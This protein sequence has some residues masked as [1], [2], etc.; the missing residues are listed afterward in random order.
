AR[1]GE[2]GTCIAVIRIAEDGR[3]SAPAI[4]AEALAAG[5]CAS[6]LE[7]VDGDGGLEAIMQ[8]TWPALAIVEA[9]VPA[10]RVALPARHGGWPAG[11]MP[12]DYERRE[13]EVRA[14]ALEQARARLD[15]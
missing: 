15:V 7:D 3:P 1:D 2:E 4:E 14:A 11:P 5:R 6:S 10:L 8:L 9:Q 12:I 13:R